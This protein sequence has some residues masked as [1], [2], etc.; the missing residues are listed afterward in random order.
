MWYSK[1]LMKQAGM[2][3]LRGVLSTVRNNLFVFVFFVLIAPLLALGDGREQFSDFMGVTVVLVFAFYC[4][5]VCTKIRNMPWGLLSFWTIF[6]GYVFIRTIF[7]QDIGYSISN[8]TRY[9][10]AF[11]VFYIFHCFGNRKRVLGFISALYIFSMFSLALA[12][13]VTY[14][15][16]FTDRLPLMNLV[17]PTY[18]HNHVADILQFGLAIAIVFSLTFRGLLYPALFLFYSMGLVFSLAR[19]MMVSSSLYMVGMLIAIKSKRPYMIIVMSVCVS[20]LVL[21][22]FVPPHFFTDAGLVYKGI[23]KSFFY[24]LRVEY[25]RQSLAAIAERPVFGSGPG[26]F[27]LA[28]HKYK[29]YEA[30]YSGYAHNFILETTVELGVLGASL[31]AIFILTNMVI[32]FRKIRARR[33]KALLIERAALLGAMSLSLANS[34][35]DYAFNYLLVWILFWSIFGLISGTSQEEIAAV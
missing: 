34:L 4:L 7:S 20:I 3:H 28:A 9:F 29:R 22:A 27:L 15:P 6:L 31:L 32:F 18:G 33:P 2:R 35:F 17:Y 14:L 19:T 13:A 1:T 8:T 24:D 21:L 16:F 26:T 30:G 23:K 5:T 10:E 25:W 11:I 12:V